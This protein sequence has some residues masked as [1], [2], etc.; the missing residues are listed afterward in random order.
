MPLLSVQDLKT[1]FFTEEGVVR[2]VDGVTYA[3]DRGEVL[4]IV[5]ESGSGKSVSS[6]STMRLIPDPP[7]RI[8]GGRILLQREDGT[9][10]DLVVAEEKR[11]R[12]IRGNRIAMIFQDPMT[13]L[14]PYLKVSDQLVEVLEIHRKM[15]RRQARD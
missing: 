10:E 6:L 7:G 1:H 12:A 9:G 5:G 2:A 13:S 3:V 4:G 15:A 11:M 8:V 14:N